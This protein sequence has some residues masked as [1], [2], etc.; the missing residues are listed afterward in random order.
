MIGFILNSIKKG[1]KK[2][3]LYKVALHYF[4]QFY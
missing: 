3:D 1:L 2:D 4:C